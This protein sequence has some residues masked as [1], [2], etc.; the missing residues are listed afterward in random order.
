MIYSK[1]LYFKY[2]ISIVFPLVYNILLGYI[3]LFRLP[4]V[5]DNEYPPQKKSF[6]MLRYMHDYHINNYEWFIRADDDIYI[7]YKRLEKLL[8][9]LNSSKPIFLGNPGF[10]MADVD[11]IEPGT[12]PRFEVKLVG[13]L[14]RLGVHR[15]IK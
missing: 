1:K 2:P 11:R 12:Y 14:I 6:M 8:Y 13:F 4:G 3:F 7:N 5:N 10:G 15:K 9:S